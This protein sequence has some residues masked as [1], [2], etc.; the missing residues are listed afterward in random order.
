MTCATP[1]WWA[2]P[3]SHPLSTPT[4]YHPS[5]RY[6]PLSGTPVGRGKGCN[7]MHTGCNPTN[8]GCDPMYPQVRRSDV[9][10]L[11]ATSYG[12]SPT[13]DFFVK[14][15]ICKGILPQVHGPTAHRVCLRFCHG[16]SRRAVLHLSFCLQSGRPLFLLS[17]SSTLVISSTAPSHDPLRLYPSRP[18]LSLRRFSRSSSA[19]A[20]TPK[21]CSRR[22]P[23]PSRR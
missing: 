23:T 19:R 21:S 2:P 3:S 5:A 7:L 6:T 9:T 4:A 11:P 15:E 16:P 17:S 22:R 12:K 20:R 10:K 18:C 14:A 8:A 13:G 1:R